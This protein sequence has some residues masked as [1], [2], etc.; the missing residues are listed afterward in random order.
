MLTFGV[1]EGL[2]IWWG[3]TYIFLK[4]NTQETQYIELDEIQFRELQD[5]LQER[6]ILPNR[7]YI[8]NIHAP[9]PLLPPPLPPPQYADTRT[10]TNL[11]S[12][13]VDDDAILK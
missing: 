12:E 11:D 3:L 2:F 4:T 6:S 9:Q 8:H 13:N 7:S 10:E 5:T 1:L